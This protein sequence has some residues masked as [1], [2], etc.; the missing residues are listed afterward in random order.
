M[1]DAEDIVFPAPQALAD[2]ETYP[3]AEPFYNGT[4][5]TQPV[6]GVGAWDISTTGR[7]SMV[8]PTASNIHDPTGP[9]G[10]YSTANG[11]NGFVFVGGRHAVNARV[12]GSATTTAGK[13]LRLV[14][15][16]NYL[17]EL[18]TPVTGAWYH[19]ILQ[20]DHTTAAVELK[21]IRVRLPK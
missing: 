16:Q 1:A 3:Q 10:Y 14:V 4:G 8:I 19:F 21:R 11:D 15:G 12:M 2:I 18:T 5:S 13:P 17:E 7:T 6:G 9:V 20:E